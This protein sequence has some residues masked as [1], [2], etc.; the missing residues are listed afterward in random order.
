M[1]STQ[2]ERPGEKICNHNGVLKHIERLNKIINL[3]LKLDRITK[4]PFALFQSSFTVTD[5][6]CLTEDE[7]EVVSLKNYSTSRLQLV[8]C[9]FILSCYAGI[10]CAI[11]S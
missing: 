8:K 1:I 7:L 9:L 2:P 3:A 10:N 11:Y 4:D 5:V 6:E